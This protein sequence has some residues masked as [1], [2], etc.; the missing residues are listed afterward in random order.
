MEKSHRKFLLV[1][2]LPLHPSWQLCHKLEPSSNQ[3]TSVWLQKKKEIKSFRAFPWLLP[4]LIGEE[5]NL[6]LL[7]SESPCQNT[8]L[9]SK[10]SGGMGNKIQEPSL[11][12]S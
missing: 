11:L 10:V 4:I 1:Y 12:P 3:T 2:L 9:I 8:G 5:R 6:K 7:R